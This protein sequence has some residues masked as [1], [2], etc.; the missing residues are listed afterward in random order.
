[1]LVNFLEMGSR[2]YDEVISDYIKEAEP[3]LTRKS[4]RA[5]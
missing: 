4:L 2:K 1:M 3:A 5:R